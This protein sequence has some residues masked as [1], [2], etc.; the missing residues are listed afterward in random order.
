ML[1]SGNPGLRWRSCI[2]PFFAGYAANNILPLRGGDVLR[3]FAFNQALGVSSGVV[4][5]TL[6]IERLLDLIILLSLFA[7]A[8]RHFRPATL[9]ITDIHIALLLTAS[10]IGVTALI[11]PK[12]GRPIS[13]CIRWLSA[14]IPTRWNRGVVSEIDRFLVTLDDLAARGIVIHLLSLSVAAWLAEGCVF[15]LVA[16]SIP[17]M[18]DTAGS[19]LALTAGNFATLI[20][21]TPGFVGT[22][23]YFVASS[24]TETGNSNVP[25]TAYALL[26]H[27]FLASLQLSIGGVYLLARAIK[28]TPSA[29]EITK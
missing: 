1:Q 9:Q 16:D 24:M 3:S 28:T 22:F 4:V 11:F 27:G 7:A 6:L 23:D 10:A 19:W 15:W 8:L 20:P 13:L 14:R 17:A 21:S 26:I 5:A 25:A 12:L 18:A 2:G 29:A